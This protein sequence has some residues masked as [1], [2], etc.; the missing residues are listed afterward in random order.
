MATVIIIA[1]GHAWRLQ[2]F[3]SS[4]CL[5]TCRAK[6]N[7]CLAATRRSFI[8]H[9]INCKPFDCFSHVYSYPNWRI[10]PHR[11]PG[12]SVHIFCVNQC[13]MC[14]I[15]STRYHS[16]RRP[17]EKSK[18]SKIKNERTAN[19]ASF[20]LHFGTNHLASYILIFTFDADRTGVWVC[21][22]ESYTLGEKEHEDDGL[23]FWSV[24]DACTWIRCMEWCAHGNG[25]A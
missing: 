16:H 18:E 9:H 7:N 4:T 14:S 5:H 25:M 19:V 2:H 10:F 15:R 6:I 24:C 17:V 20:I 1:Q 13:L 3:L 11:F 22:R 12:K 8:Y 23:Q 21:V